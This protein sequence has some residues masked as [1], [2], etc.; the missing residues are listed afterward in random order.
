[1]SKKISLILATSAI[2]SVVAPTAGRVASASEVSPT[3]VVAVEGNE[4]VVK[5]DLYI[6]FEK[7]LAQLTQETFSTSSAASSNVSPEQLEALML[8]YEGATM[9]VTV[10]QQ[11]DGITR[12][13]AAQSASYQQ[14]LVNGGLNFYATSRAGLNALRSDLNGLR[15][16]VLGG[17]AVYG[18]MG[19]WILVAGAAIVATNITSAANG[20]S[21][22]IQAGR[23]RGGARITL[24]E[25]F[26]INS[27]TSQV[28]ASI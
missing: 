14:R 5:N 15:V 21:A 9:T 16:T 28:Q 17:G 19:A 1:M 6:A 2:L 13:A 24:S 26:P 18:A 4:E 22:F 20:V 12:A 10:P 8:K 7:E 11:N 23:T 3:S 27:I 25:G